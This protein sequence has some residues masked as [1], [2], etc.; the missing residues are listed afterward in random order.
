MKRKS[1][2]VSDEKWHSLSQWDWQV[3]YLS[4]W[5]GRL[6]S[7][8]SLISVPAGASPLP[9]VLQ[10]STCVWVLLFPSINKTSFSSLAFLF[11]VPAFCRSGG[12]CT[13]HSRS[14]CPQ[15]RPDSSWHPGMPCRW[16]NILTD[17]VKR[18]DSG[19]LGVFSALLYLINCVIMNTLF[20]A[21]KSNKLLS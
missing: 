5:S 11:C 19:L 8:Q 7:Y 14:L 20:K 10:P 4:H 6:E 17:S 21:W 16:L 13:W 15:L 1:V 12:W 3:I 18:A 9:P 2:G